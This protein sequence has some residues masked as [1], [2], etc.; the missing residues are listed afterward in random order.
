LFNYA[1]LPF[2][3]GS[4]ERVQGRPDY[5][6]LT[7]MAEW[8][9][10]HGIVTKGQPLIWHEVYPS[11]APAD[12]NEAI[13][14]LHA[15]V[16]DLITHFRGRINIWDVINEANAAAN[17]PKTGVGDWALRDGPAMMVSTALS[18][19]RA[20]R[21]APTSQPS[22]AHE[23]FIYNDYEMGS[24]NLALLKELQ[25]RNALPDATGIQSHMHVAEWRPEQ[26][27]AVAER[28]ASFKRPLHFT[29]VTVLSGEHRAPDPKVPFASDWLS[30]REGENRQADYLERFYTIL[31]SH[32]AV[33]AITYWDL[34]DEGAWLG[35]P[36][37]LLRKDMTPKPAYQR[38]LELIHRQWWTDV[39]VKTDA[40][41]TCSVRAFFGDYHI[42]I[43][44]ARAKRVP[45]HLILIAGVG[46]K[47]VTITAQR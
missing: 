34:S 17:S 26:V 3:W 46:P 11:W 13:P 32:P 44:G 8:C 30:T 14:L 45:T 33:Q 5:R 4:F 37:G 15:R 22:D 36:A 12:A 23:A 10:G 38:L 43:D 24:S 7:G 29:E 18:W 2:Y 21:A 47:T 42:V 39:E 40:T 20:A 6:R 27:W 31:F 19:A 35:A 28:F 16:S 1:T 41:G 9:A 25:T